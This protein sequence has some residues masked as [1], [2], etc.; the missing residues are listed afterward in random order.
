MK[1]NLGRV[2]IRRG[3]LTPPSWS[4]GWVPCRPAGTIQPRW[5]CWC[6]RGSVGSTMSF[7]NVQ[8]SSPPLTS[9]GTAAGVRWGPISRNSHSPTVRAMLG[10]HFYFFQIKVCF[11]FADKPE[12]W[13]EQ[14]VVRSR[15]QLMP[16]E[17]FRWGSPQ[18]TA[19]PHC[20]RQDTE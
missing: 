8:G 5:R 6:E 1:G 4:K 18:Q 3:R 2:S 9:R 16:G 12:R 10:S 17:S 14:Q 13:K 19:C 15:S 20:A 7:H 11:F